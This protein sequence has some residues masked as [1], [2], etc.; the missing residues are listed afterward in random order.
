MVYVYVASDSI[1]RFLERHT[2]EQFV[3]A[4]R[5]VVTGVAVAIV[6]IVSLIV[7]KMATESYAS[8]QNDCPPSPE[9]TCP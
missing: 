4:I 7:L 1:G 9:Y 2:P 6:L 8:D 3:R 5:F